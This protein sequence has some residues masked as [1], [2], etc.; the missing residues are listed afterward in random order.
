MMVIY[1]Q[2]ID[3]DLWFSI[4]NGPHKPIKI[5][6]NII[7]PKPRSECVDDDKKLFFLLMLNL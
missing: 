3:Y 2:S 1:L 6:N 5:E 7:I 4:E